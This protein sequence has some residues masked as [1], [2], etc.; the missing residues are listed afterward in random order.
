MISFRT[1]SKSFINL[2]LVNWNLIY[3][4]H[5]SL[6]LTETI[7]RYLPTCSRECFC[8]SLL[9]CVMGSGC[10]AVG[11]ASAFATRDPKFESNHGQFYLLSRVLKLYWKEAGNSQK[12]MSCVNYP[13][14][15][16]KGIEQSITFFFG[17]KMRNN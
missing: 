10:G 13:Q 8:V 14:K 12:K 6:F 17:K 15:Q 5:W 2:R 1:K 16:N 7:N 11:R 9:S 3:M 4:S